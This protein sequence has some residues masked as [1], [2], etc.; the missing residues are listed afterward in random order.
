MT[1]KSC[2][3]FL[4]RR[5]SPNMQCS[6]CNGLFCLKCMEK[7]GTI[8]SCCLKIDCFKGRC[9]ICDNHYGCGKCLTICRHCNQS[10][11]SWC[12]KDLCSNGLK[13]RIC[14]LNDCSKCWRPKDFMVLNPSLKSQILY[15]LYI[16][17]YSILKT[18]PKVSK[19][20]I[21]QQII[22]STKDPVPQAPELFVEFNN[23]LWSDLCNRGKNNTWLDSNLT[24]IDCVIHNIN[25]DTHYIMTSMK[26]H[27]EMGSVS[28]WKNSERI[29]EYLGLRC[30]Q[31]TIHNDFWIQTQNHFFLIDSVI[32]CL[33]KQIPNCFAFLNNDYTSHQILFDRNRHFNINFDDN[34]NK[35]LVQHTKEQFITNM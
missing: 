13:C 17:K 23:K 7:H 22:A 24:K 21:C 14:H 11:C 28:I 4:G 9:L 32:Y 16:L 34:L 31:Y 3:I 19:I 29:A 1:C 8:S 35:L 2:G 20:H 18:L 12:I 10:F 30:F 33:L 15:G 6:T 26:F 25:P 27:I 5:I